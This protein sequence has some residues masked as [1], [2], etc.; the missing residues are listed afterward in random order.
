M[1]PNFDKPFNVT[2]TAIVEVTDPKNWFN[3]VF[4]HH[5]VL[6]TF[7][8]EI[9]ELDRGVFS[10]RGYASRQQPL[11]DQRREVISMAWGRDY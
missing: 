1:I 8:A 3:F 11:V 2:F 4:N 6:D 7:I 10:I 5:Q 9:N